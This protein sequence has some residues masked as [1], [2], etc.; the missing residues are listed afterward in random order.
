VLLIQYPNCC[1]IYLELIHAPE[2]KVYFSYLPP[3]AN[4]NYPWTTLKRKYGAA[5]S[6]LQRSHA[7]WHGVSTI[8]PFFRWQYLADATQSF[9][10]YTQQLCVND[11]VRRPGGIKASENDLRKIENEKA[12]QSPGSSQ[13]TVLFEP[14]GTV[15]KNSSDGQSEVS[16]LVSWKAGFVDNLSDVTNSLNISGKYRFLC[17]KSPF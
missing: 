7:D 15:V 6:S 5:I 10:S 16:Q 1:T 2:A 8:I 12:S 9:N 4:T 13:Q 3:P 14:S 11:V 17:Y